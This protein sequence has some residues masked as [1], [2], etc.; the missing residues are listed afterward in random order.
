MALGGNAIEIDDNGKIDIGRLLSDVYGPNYIDHPRIEQLCIKNALT[1]THFLNGGD[2]AKA[3][4]DGEYVKLHQ[5]TLRKVENL[6][7]IIEKA[8]EG[9]LKT[10]NSLIKLYGLTP[11]GL[12]QMAQENW[13]LA[14][15]IFII[16][17]IISYI[18]GKL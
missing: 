16:T 5:S 12:F 2:E 10:N 14:L 7:L 8:Y 13:L 17:S 18:I 3:F 1:M 11:Q 15:I 4:K 9:T 6:H